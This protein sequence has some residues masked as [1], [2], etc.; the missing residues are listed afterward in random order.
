[1]AKRL[2]RESLRREPGVAPAP[3][4]ALD[5]LNP[6]LSHFEYEDLERDTAKYFLYYAAIKAACRQLQ[7][8][9]G[10]WLQDDAST[11][12]LR[13]LVLGAGHG[14]LVTLSLEAAREA[15]QGTW[16]FSVEVLDAN[17]E[18]CTEKYSCSVYGV[19]ELG[20]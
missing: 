8:D 12:P 11:S 16:P 5:P 9:G 19:Q 4:C 6:P 1:M 17:P 3:S 7:G 13:I 10:A 14:R 20:H 15:S 2:C 18:A